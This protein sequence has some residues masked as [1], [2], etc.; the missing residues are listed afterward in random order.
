[1]Y[2][3]CE[4]IK[5]FQKY[6]VVDDV[7]VSGHLDHEDGGEGGPSGQPDEDDHQQLQR[8]LPFRLEV[9]RYLIMSA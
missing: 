6:V 4:N 8:D 3:R 9:Q 2:N 5:W 7:V 1:M